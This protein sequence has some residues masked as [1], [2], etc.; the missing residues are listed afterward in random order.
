MLIPP[1]E[2]M[3]SEVRF[4]LL[5]YPGRIHGRVWSKSRLRSQP[6][7]RPHWLCIGEQGL[8]STGARQERYCSTVSPTTSCYLSG[9]EVPPNHCMQPTPQPVIKFAYAN[10][11]P[12]LGARLMLAVRPLIRRIEGLME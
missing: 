9:A 5:R 4:S 8:L 7:R 12:V 2:V 10:L 11:S 1:E 6:L 3:A